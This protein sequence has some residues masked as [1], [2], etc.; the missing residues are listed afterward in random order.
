MRTHTMSERFNVRLQTITNFDPL[1]VEYFCYQFGIVTSLSSR[2]YLLSANE[3]IVR[4]RKTIVCR[5]WHGVEWSNVRG[6]LVQHEKI[7]AIFLFHDSSKCKL[8]CTSQITQFVAHIEPFPPKDFHRF[9]PVKY[10][11]LVRKDH[12]LGLVLCPNRLELPRPSRLQIFENVLEHDVYHLQS[13]HVMLVDGHLQI[14][15]R[16]LAQVPTSL[17]VLRAKDGPDLEHAIDIGRNRHL[18]V[19]LGRLG[20]A[21]RR[22]EV[23]GGEHP[24]SALA[25]PSDELGGVNLDEPLRVQGFSEELAHGG[26]DAHNSVV[27]GSTQ[28]QPSV[29]E[30][31]LLSETGEWSVGVLALIHLLF[32]AGGV[33]HEERKL[34]IRFRYRMNA[35]NYELC[36]LN[37]AT[38]YF[39]C[40]NYPLQIDHT[41]RR[42]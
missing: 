14:Q 1:V 8:L 42:E 40:R 39:C 24:G 29:V 7:C 18:L 37:G 2:A 9:R 36:V 38:P 23:V 41:L 12:R 11:R 19:Q 6:V 28:I 21:G 20:E 25:L 30:A 3:H 34:G 15:P 22:P 35:T 17:R 4:V 16:E 32:A 27:R 26:L 13:L 31:D 33:L 10:A 5:I